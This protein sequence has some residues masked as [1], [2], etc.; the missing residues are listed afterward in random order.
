MIK[1]L[2]LEINS[3]LNCPHYE[4]HDFTYHGGGW[5]DWCKLSK[6]DIIP[7]KNDGVPSWCELSDKQ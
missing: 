5:Q 6:K 3:C 1:E 4:Y 2:T 7:F